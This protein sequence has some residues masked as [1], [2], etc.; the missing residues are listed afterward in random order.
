MAR[1][2]FTSF[3]RSQW[4]RLPPVKTVDLTGRTVVVTGANVGLGLEAAKHFA[5]MKPAHLVLAC[6]NKEKGEAAI[7]GMKLES[8]SEAIY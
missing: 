5:R 2:P 7:A 1:L 4:T 6:R 3:I 8:Y